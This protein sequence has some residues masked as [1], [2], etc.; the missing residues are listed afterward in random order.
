MK[1]RR[2]DWEDHEGYVCEEDLSNEIWVPFPDSGFHHRYD[3]YMLAIDES[4]ETDDPMIYLLFLTRNEE[5]RDNRPC[6]LIMTPA[7]DQ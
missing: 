7:T 5:Q 2:E 4:P 3:G 6:R 1:L